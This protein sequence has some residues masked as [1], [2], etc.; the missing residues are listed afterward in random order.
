MSLGPTGL[1]CE[2]LFAGCDGWH[3]FAKLGVFVGDIHPG[4]PVVG[5]SGSPLLVNVD[6]LLDFL[7]P[8]GIVVGLENQCYLALRTRIS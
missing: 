5:V 2:C 1:K 3:V 8:F 7:L 6:A 4:G